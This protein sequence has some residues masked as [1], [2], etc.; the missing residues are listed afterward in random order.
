MTIRIRTETVGFPTEAFG[1][2]QGWEMDLV[3]AK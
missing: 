2:A 1:I 3:V